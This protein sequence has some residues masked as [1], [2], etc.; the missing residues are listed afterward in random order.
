M[1]GFTIIIPADAAGRRVR[2]K[3]APATRIVRDKTRYDRR[4]NHRIER[5]EG[6][7]DPAF[8]FHQGQRRIFWRQVPHLHSFH[9]QGY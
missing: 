6:R 7:G 8:I 2:K 1:K 3:H 9:M 5:T 4:E